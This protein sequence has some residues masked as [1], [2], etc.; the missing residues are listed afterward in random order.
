MSK[1]NSNVRSL[2]RLRQNKIETSKIYLNFENLLNKIIKK[3]TFLVAVS[4]GPDSLALTALS[5]IYAKR[6]NNKVTYILIDHGIR[7][8]SN[9]EAL[10]VKKILKKQK[11]LLNIV[12]NKEKIFKNIQNQARLIRYN[13]ISK[14][15]EKKNIKFVLTGHHSDDQVETFLMRLSRGSGVQGLSAMKKISKISKNI[16]LIRP[17]LNLKKKDL[18]QIA[19]TFFGRVIKD[20]SNENK[21]YLRT[22]IRSLKKALEKSGIHHDQIIKSINNLASTRDTLNNHIYKVLNLCIKKKKNITTINTKL[23]FAESMEV[24]LRV[25]SYA[26]KNFSKSYYPPRSKKVLNLLSRLNDSKNNKSTLGGC[27][28]EKSGHFVSIRKEN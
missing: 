27:V 2:K 7:K 1:K 19:K 13:L 23:L 8:N 11:I 16:T 26:I 9:S 15:C 22:R 6:N 5:K 21:K 24:Q 20:P 28:I 3:K 18:S 12:R 14:F 25:M 17:L 4:G 10:L